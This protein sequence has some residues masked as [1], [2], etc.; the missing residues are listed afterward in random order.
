[1]FPASTP[2]PRPAL[3]WIREVAGDHDFSENYPRVRSLHASAQTYENALV[4]TPYTGLGLRQNDRRNDTIS[5]SDTRM[6]NTNVVN[7]ARAQH[8]RE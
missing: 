7:E 6:F 3:C 1:M 4:Q 2:S 5:V 8:N